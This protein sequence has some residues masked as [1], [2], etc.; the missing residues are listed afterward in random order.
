MPCTSLTLYRCGKVSNLEPLRGMP[1]TFL[2]IQATAV[3]DLSPLADMPL[4]ELRFDA[5]NIDSGI[6]VLRGMKSLKK[7]NPNGPTI[8]PDEFWRRYD[9]GEFKK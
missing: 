5:K 4:V 6:N 9:A 2:N 8:S 3:T 1:L 7:I